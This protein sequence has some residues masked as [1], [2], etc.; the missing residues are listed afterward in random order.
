MTN[1]DKCVTVKSPAK[2]ILIEN[3]HCNIS[4]GIAIGSLGADTNISNVYYRNLYINKAD[5]CYLKSN[6]GSGTV[7]N[8]V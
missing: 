1:G 7:E 6:G 3:I 2:N 4:G 5:A 8:I